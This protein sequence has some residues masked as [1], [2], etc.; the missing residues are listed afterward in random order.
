[1]EAVSQHQAPYTQSR[2]PQTKTTHLIPQFC[3]T[4]KKLD[5]RSYRTAQRGRMFMQ[6]MSPAASPAVLIQ[7][8][9]RRRDMIRRK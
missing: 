8:E 1:M 9:R 6:S 4:E 2:V 7:L 5:K 3:L